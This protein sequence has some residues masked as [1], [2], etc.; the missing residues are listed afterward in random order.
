MALRCVRLAHILCVLPLLCAS[1]VTA[2]ASSGADGRTAGV[3]RLPG[4][5]VLFH[6]SFVTAAVAAA[7]QATTH[8]LYDLLTSCAT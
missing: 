7:D 1:L 8:R 6:V 3:H 5:A 2:A 4:S